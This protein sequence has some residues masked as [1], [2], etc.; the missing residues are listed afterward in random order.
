MSKELRV[1]SLPRTHYST[2]EKEFWPVTGDTREGSLA[3]NLD[4]EVWALSGDLEKEVWPL[5]TELKVQFL[6]QTHYSILEKEFWPFTGNCRE[7]SLA[8]NLDNEVWPFF[9]GIKVISVPQTQ[10]FNPRKEH[11]AIIWAIKSSFFTLNTTTQS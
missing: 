2:L 11:L 5:S 9:C 6:P 4:K 1:H 3:I 10:L 8:I 7:G